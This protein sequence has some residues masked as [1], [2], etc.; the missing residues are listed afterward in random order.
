M[1]ESITQVLNIHSLCLAA[2]TRGPAGPEPNRFFFS[3]SQYSVLIFKARGVK[4]SV[5]LVVESYNKAYPRPA[6][7]PERAGMGFFFSSSVR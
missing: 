6:A 2:Q 1:S 5:W 3:A 7:E 4:S